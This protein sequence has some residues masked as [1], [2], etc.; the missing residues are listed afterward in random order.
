MKK[1]RISD[2]GLT[3]RQLIGSVP[4]YVHHN[5]QYVAVA[6]A[7]KKVDR[8]GTVTFET[9]T[10]TSEIGEKPRK[11]MQI[12]TILGGGSRITDRGV[13]VKVQC[14][15]EYHM[16]TCEVALSRYNA[17]DIIYSNGMY[18]W[19]TNPKGIPTICKHVYIVLKKLMAT[20]Q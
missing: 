10:R 1:K 11:H 3:P 4:G 12:I 17:A 5:G 8:T 19:T 16:Y 20:R 9:Q 18:P 6:K 2:R 7:R 13:R 14:D 15:C